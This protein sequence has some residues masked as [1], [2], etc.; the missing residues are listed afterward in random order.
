MVVRVH[1]DKV[2]DKKSK[3]PKIACIR[4]IEGVIEWDKLP[5]DYLKVPPHF[6]I[7]HGVFTVVEK[8]IYN[9][10]KVLVEIPLKPDGTPS[11][12]SR[13]CGSENGY[14]MPWREF[15]KV[16]RVMRIAGE[17]LHRINQA[18]AKMK[19]EW[20]ESGIVVEI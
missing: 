9:E 6:Y 1:F 12:K 10:E 20:E 4:K 8:G 16:L 11:Y 17:R 18:H 7:R 14:P 19:E 5:K 13:S 15:K 2:Y 3:E